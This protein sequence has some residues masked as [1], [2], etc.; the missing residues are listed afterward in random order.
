MADT[1][2]DET[3]YPFYRQGIR[4]DGVLYRGQTK[5][6]SV[7]I[8]RNERLGRV[9][10]LDGVVQTTEGDEFYYHESMTHP[11]MFAHGRVESVLIIGGADGGIL[12]EVLRHPVKEV[13]IVDID[14]EL[15][16]ICRQHLP[17]H[18]AGAFEDPRTVNLPGDGAAYVAE[19]DKRFDVI[20]VD[21]TDPQGPG[22][23][24]FQAPFF[25]NCLRVLKKGGLMVTQNGVSYYQPDELREA[26][27][28][29]LQVFEKAGAYLSPIPAYVGGHMAFGWASQSLDLPNVPGPTIRRRLAASGIET[30]H[31]NPEVHAAFFALPNNIRPLI[32][33]G[34]EEGRTG[35]KQL[36]AGLAEKLGLKRAAPKAKA[37]PKA[38]KAPKTKKVKAAASPKRAKVAKAAKAAKRPAKRKAAATKASKPKAAAAKGRSRKVAKVRKAPKKAARRAKR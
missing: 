15:I 21:S 4:V 11:A 34:H 24:L 8:I 9:L 13:V 12:R 22:I 6:Q 33:E 37:A 3:L 31:Y 10:C 38:T 25:L 35:L 1:W 5:F 18:H 32:A 29:R 14:G 19:T 16:D 23:V 17:L 26:H 30:R 27:H 28:H 7:E 36:W 2:F 20:L